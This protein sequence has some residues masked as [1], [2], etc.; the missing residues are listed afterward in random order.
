MLLQAESAK[1][2]RNFEQTGS[3]ELFAEDAK[4]IEKALG[5]GSS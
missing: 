2:L 3:L 1:P 5:K 4:G